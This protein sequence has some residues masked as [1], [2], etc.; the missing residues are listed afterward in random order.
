MTR[1]HVHTRTRSRPSPRGPQTTDRPR[2]T[3]IAD[4]V[5]IKPADFTKSSIVAIQD[6]INTKYANKVSLPGPKILFSIS[7]A[8]VCFKGNPE[9][10][11]LHL[12]VGHSVGE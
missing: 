3:K 7:G 4:L 10:R 5:E 12:S 2:Q 6:H 9:S 11:T 1:Q 8:D